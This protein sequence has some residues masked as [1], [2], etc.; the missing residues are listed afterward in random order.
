MQ[1]YALV[2]FNIYEISLPKCTTQQPEYFQRHT[3]HPD[4][5]NFEM[6]KAASKQK[7]KYYR[8]CLQL[9]KEN[10]PVGTSQLL[11][12][13]PQRTAHQVHVI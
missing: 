6:S 9:T 1:K 3:A 10:T 11:E 5:I 4:N 7:C 12:L 2:I 8:Q 13:V